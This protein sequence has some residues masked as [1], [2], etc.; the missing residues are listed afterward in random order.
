M[1]FNHDPGVWLRQNRSNTIEM[2]TSSDEQPISSLLVVWVLMIP[3]IYL[4]SRGQLWFQAENTA[5]GLVDMSGVSLPDQS[6][7]NI[8]ITGSM[9][10]VMSICCFKWSREIARACSQASL[11][12][13]LAAWATASCVW[14]Q[15]PSFSFKMGMYLVVNTAFG[16]FLYRRFTQLQ[17][18]RLF[19]LLGWICLALSYALCLFFPQFGFDATAALGG[20]AWRGMY[21]YKNSCAMTTTFL[22][23]VGLFLPTKSIAAKIGKLAFNVLSIVLIYFTQSRTGWVVLIFLLAYLFA[24]KVG[25]IFDGANRTALLLLE[26]FIAVPVVT[27]LYIDREALT[28]LIGKDPT[29][30]GRSDIWKAVL[31]A[32]SNRPIL[33]YGYMGFFH[34]LEGASVNLTLASGWSVSAAHNGFLDVWVMLGAV[35]LALLVAAF[36]RAC[37][38]TFICLRAEYSPYLAWCGSVILLLIVTNMDERAAVVPNDLI[39]VFCV[40]SCA[41]VA[42]GAK[43][44]RASTETYALRG[45]TIK[46]D[47]L[48]APVT[49]GSL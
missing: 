16:L 32:I 37:K 47:A 8:L 29:L 41:G 35:G 28:Y 44:I 19:Y 39:W 45:G 30:S 40:I 22:L 2:S 26:I 15:F 21:T 31:V 43:R 3:L 49:H 34:G 7:K 42:D 12:I 25:A 11:L 18:M 17:Q 14:S 4:A 13:A 20:D 48:V 27:V 23:S 36:A 10:A 1:R 6:G 46:R 5:Q 24:T 9:L 38:D 33:G